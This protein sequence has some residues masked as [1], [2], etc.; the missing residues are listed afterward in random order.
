[1]CYRI[2][3][4]CA[5]DLMSVTWWL[6]VLSFQPVAVPAGEVKGDLLALQLIFQLQGDLLGLQLYEESD[7]SQYPAFSQLQCLQVN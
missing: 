7:I 4:V 2:G 6:M 3:R 1:M 5:S